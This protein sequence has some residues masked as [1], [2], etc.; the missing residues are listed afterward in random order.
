MRSMPAPPSCTLRHPS[1]AGRGRRR[2][3][4]RCRVAAPPAAP[5]TLDSLMACVIAAV[6]ARGLC[7]AMM[8]RMAKL[9]ES[10]IAAMATHCG[11]QDCF[12]ARAS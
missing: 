7:A 1:S 3:S 2:C 6:N 11:C 5:A 12:S 9:P 8:S 10:E 4:C